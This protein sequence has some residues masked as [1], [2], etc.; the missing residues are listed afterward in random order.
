[1][2]IIQSAKKRMRQEAV[3]RVRNAATTR[4]MRTEIKALR[5]AVENKNSKATADMLRSAQSQIS[6]ALKKN[7]LH[8]NT[9][10]RKLSNLS[11]LA[12][13]V[14]AK[15]TP[16]KVAAKKPAAPKAKTTKPKASTTKPK[17]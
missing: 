14:G 12:K 15:P 16:A 9:A 1:M 11:R 7:L 10:A 13:S 8:K 5:T 17:S 4:T 6:K 3:R 2:P